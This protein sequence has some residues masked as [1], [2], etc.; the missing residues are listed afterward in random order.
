MPQLLDKV[1]SNVSLCGI[2]LVFSGQVN[3]S[4]IAGWQPFYNQILEDADLQK[5]YASISTIDFSEETADKNGNT[6][7]KQ[8][9]VFRF[10]SNDKLRAERIELIKKIKFLKLFQADG[11]VLILGRND[12]FQNKKPDIIIKSNYR[13]TEVEFQSVSISPAGFTPNINQYGLPSFIPLS[14]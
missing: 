2:E 4:N 7:Y 5:A 12:V 13:T 6:Y 1:K 11:R 3:A 10:P 8:K 14:F 9:A